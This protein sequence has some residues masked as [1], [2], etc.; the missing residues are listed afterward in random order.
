M[1]QRRHTSVMTLPLM[2]CRAKVSTRSDQHGHRTLALERLC[3]G[4]RVGGLLL[5]IQGPVSQV[6]SGHV[7]CP[8]HFIAKTLG[9][10]QVRN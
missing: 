4:Q 10:F 6:S 7:Q 8:H 9:A 2:H 1:D 3:Q 5:P